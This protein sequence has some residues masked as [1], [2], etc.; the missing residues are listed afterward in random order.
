MAHAWAEQKERSNP[1]TLK[2]ICWLALHTSRAF[3]RLLLYPITA[4]FYVT[5]PQARRASANYL[6]RV[7]QRPP[8]RRDVLRHIHCFAATILD[9]VYFLTD[10]M[11]R[12]DIEMVGV[13]LFDDYVRHKQGCILLGAHLGSFD[14]LRSLA[15]NRSEIRL[16]IMMYHDHNAM[17]MRVLDSLNA[18]VAEAIINLADDNAL[19]KMQEA[20]EQG[21]MVGTLAD[22]SGEEKTCTC[23]L[24]GEAVELPTGP[25]TIATIVQAPVLMF[26]PLYLGG[27][28]YAIYFEKLSEP[29]QVPR[30]ERAEVV[31]ALAQQYAS[32]L[33][34][35]IKLAPLNWFNFYDYWRD[36]KD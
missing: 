12:F 27:N 17:M 21:D 3:A 24:L 5:A 33:E 31:A 10:Q 20:L 2:L 13:E 18:R 25:L 30:S 23:Q 4:Y 8:T 6:R 16:K 19:L 7:W 36:E 15:I 14:A 29:L 11:E 26:F 35:Y 28:R 9:R 34:H 1:L 22:R 32:R